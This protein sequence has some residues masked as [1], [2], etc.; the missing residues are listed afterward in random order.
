MAAQS[1]APRAS[2]LDMATRT[3]HSALGKCGI[4]SVNTASLKGFKKP[5]TRSRNSKPAST[6]TK[7]RSRT[8]ERQL[9]GKSSKQERVIGI[10]RSPAG[11]TIGAMM[12]ATGWLQ[13]SVRGFF[14]GV[15]RK[16]LKLKLQSTKVDGK[17]IY[18]INSET[19]SNANKPQSKRRAA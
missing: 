15:V 13:H 2:D 19:M 16:K 18:R 3:L 1:I 11:T 10:L 14:A 9:R 6:T 4:V 12:Q 17:R 5:A 7:P 8:P